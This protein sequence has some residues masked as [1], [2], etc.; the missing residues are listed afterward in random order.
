MKLR[1]WLKRFL[2]IFRRPQYSLGDLV[3]IANVPHVIIGVRRN[4]KYAVFFYRVGENFSA[5][6]TVLDFF[7]L[8]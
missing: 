5:S 8:N 2:F 6:E 3:T 7:N 4:W 1:I